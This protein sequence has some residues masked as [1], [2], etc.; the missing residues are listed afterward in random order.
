MKEPSPKLSPNTSINARTKEGRVLHLPEILNGEGSNLE[1]LAHAYELASGDIVI[2]G[3]DKG[4]NYNDD[5]PN[6]DRIATCPSQNFVSVIDGMGGYDSGEVAAEI[7]ANSFLASPT[8]IKLAVANAKEEMK[9]R[10]LSPEVGAVFISARIVTEEQPDKSTAK[11]LE[12]SQ[13]GDA[14]LM[15]IKKDRTIGFQS[16]DQSLVQEKVDKGEI[17]ADETLYHRRRNTVTAAVSRSDYQEPKTYEKIGVETGDLVLLMSDG[18]ADNFTV[19][20]IAKKVK[21]GLSVGELFSWLANET[22][23]RMKNYEKIIGKPNKD[24][25]ESPE[26]IAILEKRKKDGVY[27]DGYKSKPKPDNRALAIIEI[28]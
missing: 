22:R 14:R 11:F 12:V 8:D 18:F 9:K 10:G 23:E 21:E 20:E 1:T 24:R 25:E 13:L 16:K 5:G 4:I 27:S 3:T 17:S 7:L 6:E 15:V 28:K 19:D 26:Q 2:A